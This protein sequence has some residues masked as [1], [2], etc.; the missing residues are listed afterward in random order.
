MNLYNELKDKN[1][2]IAIQFYGVND[3][4]TR[5]ECADLIKYFDSVKNL[6]EK[7]KFEVILLFK[8]T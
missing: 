8:I 5:F 4:V 3:L 6:I 1:I 7:V 2:E